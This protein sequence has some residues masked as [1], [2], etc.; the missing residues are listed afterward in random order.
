MCKAFSCLVTR[1]GEVV[2]EAGVDSHNDLLEKYGAK[3]GLKDDKQLQQAL[4]Q[5]ITDYLTKHEQKEH[6]PVE[7]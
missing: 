1:K 7:F 3:Y 2:W 5:A 4:E 6:V